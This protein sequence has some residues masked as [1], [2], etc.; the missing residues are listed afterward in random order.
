ME[1]PG[2]KYWTVSHALTCGAPALFTCDFRGIAAVFI[3]K[4]TPLR[5]EDRVA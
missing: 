5:P 4:G 1:S 3:N 2:Q